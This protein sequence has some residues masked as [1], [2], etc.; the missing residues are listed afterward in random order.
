MSDK[1][2]I[3]DAMEHMKNIEGF[4]SDV[5]LEKLPKPLRYFGY[6]IISFFSISIIIIIIGVML[7]KYF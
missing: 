1:K 6:F 5:D 7:L 4:L 2:P 3:N